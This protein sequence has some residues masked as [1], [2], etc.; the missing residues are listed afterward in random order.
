MKNYDQSVEI[1]HN[2]NWPNISDHP[3]RILIIYVSGSGKTNVLLNLIK[4]QGPDIYKVYLY[5]KDS[6]ESKYQ[7]LINGIETV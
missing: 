6:F 7:L 3:Y 1:Y 5:I 2:S 4:H